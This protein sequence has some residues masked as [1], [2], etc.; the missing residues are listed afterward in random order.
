MS[1]AG[2]V[3]LIGPMGAGKSTIGR[4]L[5]ELLG[6]EFQDSDHEIESRTGASIPLIFEI[7]G[8]AGFRKRE[9]AV[10][11]DL[12][13]REDVVLATGGRAAP[14]RGCVGE[15]PPPPAGRRGA[16]DRTPHRDAETA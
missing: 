8:E 5:A 11:D 10:L 9:S 16:R 4:A 7:E 14:A 13:R 1:R 3:F 15:P 6:K 12:T 2:N